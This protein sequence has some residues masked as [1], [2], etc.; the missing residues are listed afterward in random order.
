ML[1]SFVA[2]LVCEHVLL[3]L[4]R[5]CSLET[6]VHISDDFM[7]LLHILFDKFE[8]SKFLWSVVCQINLILLGLWVY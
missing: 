7:E 5:K 4:D 2:Y 6:V 3:L 1:K 8:S